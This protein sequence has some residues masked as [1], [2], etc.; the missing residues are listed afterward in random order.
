MK[1]DARRVWRENTVAL[2]HRSLSPVPLFLIGPRR[3][4]AKHASCVFGNSGVITRGKIVGGDKVPHSH[5][6]DADAVCFNRT[7]FLA[8][9]RNGRRY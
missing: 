8:M 4:V 1:S 7:H 6:V 9:P 5:C 3:A 2:S